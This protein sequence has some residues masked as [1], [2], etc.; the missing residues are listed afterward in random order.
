MRDT[1]IKVNQ[2]RD[3]SKDIR[4]RDVSIRLSAKPKDKIAESY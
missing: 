1:Y 4:T 3:K 2:V